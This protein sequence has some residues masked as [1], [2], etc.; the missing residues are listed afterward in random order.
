VLL[1]SSHN[2]KWPVQKKTT[3]MTFRSHEC[4]FRESPGMQGR[5]CLLFWV[6]AE[7]PVKRGSPWLLRRFWWWLSVIGILYSQLCQKLPET[8]QH[9]ICIISKVPHCSVFPVFMMGICVKVRLSF[10]KFIFCPPWN[11]K[12]VVV[13][14]MYFLKIKFSFIF[15]CTCVKFR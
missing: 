11:E 7:L 15:K 6:T 12:M 1:W 3:L 14:K 9:C 10:Y 13:H 2:S 8:F 4:R 5:N